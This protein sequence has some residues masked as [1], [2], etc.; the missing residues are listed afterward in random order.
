MFAAVI[1]SFGDFSCEACWAAIEGVT[2]FEGWY[3]ICVMVHMA[4]DSGA[5]MSQALVPQFPLCC[6]VHLVECR[7][8][9]PVAVRWAGCIHVVVPEVIRFR[10]GKLEVVDAV[11]AVEL[12][13]ACAVINIA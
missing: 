7:F 1:C 12:Y 6:C 10:D 3:S 8:V 2:G 4:H 11:A 9:G 5:G 13:K